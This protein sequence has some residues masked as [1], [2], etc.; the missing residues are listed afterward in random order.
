MR[1]WTLDVLNVVRRLDKQE[2]ELSEGYGFADE[3][4]QLHPRN[5]YIEPKIRQQLQRLRDLGF[6]EFVVSGRYRLKR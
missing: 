6:L 5:R 1:G 3:L 4:S 2:F